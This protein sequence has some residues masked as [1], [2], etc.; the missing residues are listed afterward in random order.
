MANV[1]KEYGCLEKEEDIVEWD[2]KAIINLRYARQYT[3]HFKV[4]YPHVILT[5]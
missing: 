5:T 3:E 1:R 4:H 2:E